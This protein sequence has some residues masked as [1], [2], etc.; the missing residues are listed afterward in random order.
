M[1]IDVPK[2]QWLLTRHDGA[3]ATRSTDVIVGGFKVMLGDAMPVTLVQDLAGGLIGCLLGEAID[4]SQQSFFGARYTLPWPAADVTAARIENWIA[5]L[6]GAFTLAISVPAFSR[7]YP[8]ATQSFVY[9][10]EAQRAAATPLALLGPIAYG[11]R[12]DRA[13]V[14]TMEI[15][16]LGW[17]PAGLTAHQGVRRLIPNHALDLKSWSPRR[18][19]SGPDTNAPCPDTAQ[20]IAAT[21]RIMQ[22]TM[23]TV[24][25]RYQVQLAFTAGRDSRAVL[26]ASKS[27]ASK[28][29]MF[30]IGHDTAG[31][32]L[33]I[34]Q[35]IGRAFQIPHGL[36]PQ[37]LASS[38]QAQ[39][40]LALSGHTVGGSNLKLH[41]T[42]AAYG[43]SDAIVTG[44]AGEVGRG[45]YWNDGDCATTPLTAER[46]IARMDLKPLPQVVA[47]MRTWLG[48]L[49]GVDTLRVLDLAYI[50]L[51]MGCWS[52]PQAHAA[53]C[54]HR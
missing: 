26:A 38:N 48:E 46:L 50:E 23:A 47:A 8:S 43:A 45:F 20:L 16:Q 39:R 44:A 1:P 12:L 40:W 9:D 19:W 24:A 32:D 37:R 3:S 15:E 35:Q 18:T 33:E 25:G 6:G 34:P 31:P 14:Q 42:V 2:R 53:G 52:A 30:T 13:L 4:L 7:L 22:S 17:L 21:G 28:L 36:I 10:A 5:D 29:R 11:Q 27:V 41:Q 51:R 54:D 49:Q